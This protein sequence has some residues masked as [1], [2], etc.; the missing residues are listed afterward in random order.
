M[1]SVIG[2]IYILFGP[3]FSTYDEKYDKFGNLHVPDRLGAVYLAGP[4]ILLAIIFHP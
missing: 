4:C 3:L 2:A 1:L